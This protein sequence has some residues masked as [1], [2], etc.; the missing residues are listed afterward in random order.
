MLEGI[1]AVQKA[2]NTSGRVSQKMA[3]NTLLLDGR[4]DKVSP[5]QLFGTFT[6]DF[7]P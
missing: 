1:A 6:S 4:G 3:E 7:L 5:E 2:L